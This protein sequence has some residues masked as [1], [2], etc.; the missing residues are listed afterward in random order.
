MTS[1]AVL[2]TQIEDDVKFLPPP[3]QKK[4]TKIPTLH[5]KVISSDK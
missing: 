5:S 3:S 4:K 2:F 1:P